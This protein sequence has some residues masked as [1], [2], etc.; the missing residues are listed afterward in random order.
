MS[1]WR[2]LTTDEAIKYALDPRND[3]GQPNQLHVMAFAYDSDCPNDEEHVSSIIESNE[4]FWN[5]ERGWVGEADATEFTL[6]E[7]LSLNL[8][9]G[10]NVRWLHGACRCWDGIT[11]DDVDT[12]AEDIENGDTEGFAEWGPFQL[13]WPGD[14]DPGEPRD[15]T[16]MEAIDRIASFLGV[17]EDHSYSLDIAVDV[18]ARF[19][20]QVEDHGSTDL[21]WGEPGDCQDRIDNDPDEND[22]RHYGDPHCIWCLQAS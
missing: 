20:R 6:E 21:E 3:N 11:S 14:V 15:F 19:V 16:P 5:N 13:Q 17:F 10:T 8:P 7:S 22:G 4:G 18:L 1:G 2:D 12:F 9:E